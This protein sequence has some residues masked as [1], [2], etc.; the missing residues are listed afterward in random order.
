MDTTPPP[1]PRKR[2]VRCPFDDPEY[3]HVKYVETKVYITGHVEHTTSERIFA[4]REDIVADDDILYTATGY[5]YL[6][7]N[8]LRALDTRGYAVSVDDRVKN[9]LR[10]HQLVL[11]KLKE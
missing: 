4:R 3:I 5:S 6:G 8:P 1:A 10:F 11:I 2:R 7:A 9:N